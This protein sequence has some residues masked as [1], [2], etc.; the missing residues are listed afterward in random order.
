VSSTNQPG[1]YHGELNQPTGGRP[2]VRDLLVTVHTPAL[3]SGRALRTYGVARALAAHRG[4][5]LLYARFGAPEPD[6]AFR[7]IPGIELHAVVPSR[8]TRRLIAYGDARLHGVPAAI[9]RGVSPELA[10]AAARFAN[11][12]DRGRVI[13]DGP[14]TAAALRRL[15]RKRPVIYNAHNFESGFRHELGG[16]SGLGSPR[17][18]RAFERGLLAGA[19][20]SWMASE[21]DLAAARELCPTA[22]LRYVP[23]VVDVAAI[24]PI[25]SAPE[26][27]RAIF[28]ANFAYEPNRNGLYFLLTEVLPRVWAQLPDAKL[29]LVGAGLEGQP[30]GDSDDRRGRTAHADSAHGAVTGRRQHGLLL[31][32]WPSTDPRVEVL[33]FV[34]DLRTAYAEARCAVVPLLQG[35]GTPLKLIE[36]LAY[37]LPVIATPRAVAGLAVRNGEH[38]LVADGAEAFADALIRVLRDGAPELGRHGR[39]LAAERYSIE[40]LSGP[41]ASPSA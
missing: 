9:A 1:E 8:S 6:A 41:L 12:P 21:A 27:Q 25:D 15:M 22:R 2:P 35:G 34:E 18:L 30:H 32:E 20:E 4:L 13:A 31:G 33:G 26:E 29:A 3:G 19:C 36:A 5:D 14:V 38:C 24:D 17:A 40:A 10:A 7:A 16:G 37:G 11:D 28:V 23:N 39:E